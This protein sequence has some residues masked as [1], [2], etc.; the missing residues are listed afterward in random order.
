MT[1]LDRLPL[2][3]RAGALRHALAAVASLALIGLAVPVQA[4]DKVVRSF[5]VGSDLNAAGVLPGGND[6]E[7]SG[8]S[9]IY[10]GPEGK[11]Y[12]LDQINGRVLALDPGGRDAG[13]VKAM[14]LPDGLKPTDLVAN[15]KGLFVWD[16]QVHALETNAAASEGGDKLEARAV[17]AVDDVT[18]SAFAQMGS[19]APASEEEL[20]EAAAGRSLPQ[21]A[22][23]APV[24]QF[25]A[26][27]GLGPVT[28]DVIPQK[29][30]KS[31]V[32]ELRQQADPLN[33]NRFRVEVTDRIGAVEVLEV[34]DKGDAYV[35]VENVPTSIRQKAATYVARFTAKGKLD[36]VF[37]LPIS[38]DQAST[39]RSVT[40]SEKG[41]V[42][43]LKADA[44]AV[45]IV[46]L[47]GRAPGGTV[48][49]PAPVK[50]ASAGPEDDPDDDGLI[51]AV[52][53]STRAAV[54]QTG[55]AFE[56]FRWNVTPAN[57]GADP[58][59]ACSGFSR[60]RRP[61]Y[62]QG[63]VGQQVRGVPYCWGCFG[64][65]A[66]FQRKA[67]RGVLAGN[68]CTRDDPRRDTAGV[69]CSAFVSATWGL[70]RHFTTRDIP[71]ITQ[72]IANPWDMK[73]GDALNKPGSHVMLF[74]RF[75]PDRKAEVLEAAT[76]GCNGRVCRNVYPLSTL[77]A[78]G[79]RPVRYPALTD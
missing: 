63:K 50:V 70:S 1:T 52:R 66:Q 73:P 6:E 79:Y 67:E 34:G 74:V 55:L 19:Q 7:A 69:D 60:I 49:K 43:F 48:L 18:R 68:V 27:R 12:V 42:F 21:E 17:A 40:I 8:P 76:G 65:L 23:Q 72:E 46:D 58:D 61:W 13:A 41:N 77:L 75:T 25:L 39:R 31:A 33:V 30:A 62:I 22:M 26:S 59:T 54:I 47:A 56:A 24:K 57:Y 15:A 2:P 10:A 14:A 36:K 44:A 38:A 78:R 4:Q 3:P 9:A 16:G 11:L 20:L 29:T 28:I 45:N 53:P 5:K 64:S 51:A 32:V 71:S 37:D 35:F